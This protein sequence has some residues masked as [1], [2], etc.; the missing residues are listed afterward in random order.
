MSIPAPEHGRVHLINIPTV[1]VILVNFGVDIPSGEYALTWANVQ[2]LRPASWQM[3]RAIERR[4]P[5]LNQ[6]LRMPNM[7]LVC[8]EYWSV[9]TQKRVLYLWWSDGVHSDGV[10]LFLSPYEKR[11]WFAFIRE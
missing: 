11:A 10:D 9:G 4:N 5:P 1:E 2:R 7:T 6:E 3:L 8:L